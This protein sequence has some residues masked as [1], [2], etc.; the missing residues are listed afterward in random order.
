M[1]S[2]NNK[3]HDEQLSWWSVRILLTIEVAVSSKKKVE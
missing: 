2:N 1:L 3:A